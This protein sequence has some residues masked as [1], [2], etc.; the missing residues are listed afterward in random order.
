MELVLNMVRQFQL[1]DFPKE[2][3][4]LQ[5]AYSFKLKNIVIVDVLT[6]AAGF[7]LR[8]AA[9]RLSRHDGAGGVRL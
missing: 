5:I 7:V 2:F 3:L 6:I 9:C 8:V 1:K 4:L